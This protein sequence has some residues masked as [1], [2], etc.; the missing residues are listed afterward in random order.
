MATDH[1]RTVEQDGDRGHHDRRLDQEEH[2]KSQEQ[3]QHPD[4]HQL[5]QDEDNN[6]D[7]DGNV[8]IC[9]AGSRYRRN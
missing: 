9:D 6:Q 8:G 1:E 7:D 4:N 5:L 2:E 3:S